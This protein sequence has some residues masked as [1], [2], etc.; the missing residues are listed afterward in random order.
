MGRNCTRNALGDGSFENIG[1]EGFRC[2][3]PVP[4][5]SEYLLKSCRGVTKVAERAHEAYYSE[6]E[7]GHMTI[8]TQTV[9]EIALETPA[10]I[11][12][13]EQFGIDYCCGGRIPLDEACANKGL[14]I[15]EV[16][17]ALEKASKEPVPRADEWAS[18]L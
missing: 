14:A 18:D 3:N 13:F 7:G 4:P 11:R 6:T 5:T 10:S 17:A 8:A 12:V 9:R 15:A 2:L 16:I 1:P